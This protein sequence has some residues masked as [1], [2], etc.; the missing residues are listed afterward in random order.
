M[1]QLSAKYVSSFNLVFPLMAKVL[2]TNIT[3]VALNIQPDGKVYIQNMVNNS[4]TV[5]PIIGFAK[6]ST[7]KADTTTANEEN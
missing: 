3:N 2:N 1:G 6:Y 7:L 5:H 4:I